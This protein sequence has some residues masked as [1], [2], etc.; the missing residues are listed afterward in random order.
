MNTISQQDPWEPYANKGKGKGV[1]PETSF[2]GAIFAG[3][4]IVFV[5]ISRFSKK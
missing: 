2:Y 1:V 3:I 5:I 4:S